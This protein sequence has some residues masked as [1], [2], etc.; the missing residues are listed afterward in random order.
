M[1]VCVCVCIK[2]NETT[3][4]R[5]CKIS[6]IFIKRELVLQLFQGY[7]G[8]SFI[9]YDMKELNRRKYITRLL[10]NGKKCGN[11]CG[12]VL[13]NKKKQISKTMV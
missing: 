4:P 9:R 11:W 8:S 12:F 3:K 7:K 10:K 5:Q 13:A 1:S 2:S 6:R